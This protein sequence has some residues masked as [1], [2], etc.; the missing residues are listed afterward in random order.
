MHSVAI[1]LINLAS[2]IAFLEDESFPVN[3]ILA[4]FQDIL[5]ITA[6]S[7]MLNKDN[8]IKELTLLNTTLL[9]LRSHWKCKIFPCNAIN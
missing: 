5:V 9:C 6:G 7:R 8:K 4:M 2:S 3:E 1:S